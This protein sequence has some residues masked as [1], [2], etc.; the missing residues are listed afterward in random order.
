MQDPDPQALQGP[1]REAG[2]DVEHGD[3]WSPRASALVRRGELV[4]VLLGV[5]AASAALSRRSP[6]PVLADAGADDVDLVPGGDL[7]PHPLPR[8]VQPGR[9]L[10]HRHD[11]GADR[12]APAGELPQR[13]HLQVAVHGHRD[14]PGDRG[15]GHHQQ[16]RAG[17]AVVPAAQR[18]TLFHP[19]P[20]LFVDHQ[21]PEVGEPHAV[22]DEGVGPD[23]DAGG[24]G[25]RVQEGL[26]ALR[27]G[28]GTG[29]QG[30]PGGVLRGAQLA[31]GR[32]VSEQ[33]RQRPGVL[34]GEHLG[35]GQQRRL[36]T[37]VHRLEHRPQGH[38]RLARPH[39]AL[40]QPVHGVPGGEVLGDR[41]T[42]LPL[43][44]RQR[45]REPLVEGGQQAVADR[46]ARRGGSLLDEMPT[47]HQ[48][49]LD[50]QGLVPLEPL[51]GDRQLPVVGGPVDAPD[52]LLEAQQ[53]VPAAEV[54]GQRVLAP[55]PHVQ[56][57]ADAA[58]DGP[59][60]EPLGRRVDGDQRGGELLGRRL[61]VAV[62]SPGLGNPDQ[63]VLG[64]GELERPPIAG[65]LPREEPAPAR[66]QL[67]FAP[68]LVEEGAVQGALPVGDPDLEDRPA[69]RAHGAPVDPVDLGQDG[70][71]L[72]GLQPGDARQ[73]AALGV[74]PREVVEQVTDGADPQR[75][76]QGLGGLG[77]EQGL[78]RGVHRGHCPTSRRHHRDEVPGGRRRV[79]PA[80][81]TSAERRPGGRRA[82]G[83]RAARG[84]PKAPAAEA[85]PVV[86][87]LAGVIR[88][89]PGG[90]RPG[91]ARRTR[92][93]PPP[94]GPPAAAR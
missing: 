39:L 10:R 65:D 71:V 55:L 35:R 91:P 70:G 27:G 66:E 18:V 51:P 12:G 25:H 31:L 76:L 19:E 24:T 85:E 45:E 17:P 5:P 84:R 28:Q 30:E 93:T 80:P 23:D 63:L 8:P 7:L 34:G 1:L 92:S 3:R 74:P 14:R 49:E 26:P 32:Q 16:V 81:A 57:L 94:G 33:F 89:P 42:H 82:L 54:G 47:S 58:G 41:A 9:L 52:G 15:G 2:G 90:S 87:G 67:A 62:G 38:H 50:G 53:V 73:L 4:E 21:Q 48:R 22:L 78:Q 79:R 60:G 64:V 36:P 13:G 69:P 40:D 43:P 83:A 6:R 46:G 77:P 37:S 29:E 72:V 56:H 88:H 20:V 61:F 86:V 11:R 59:G 44:R 75:R 68:G